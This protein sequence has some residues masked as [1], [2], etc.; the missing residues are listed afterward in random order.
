MESLMNIH[1]MFDLIYIEEDLNIDLN[2]NYD[3]QCLKDVMTK[4][5]FVFV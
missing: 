1:K 5:G 2:K 4:H 3:S